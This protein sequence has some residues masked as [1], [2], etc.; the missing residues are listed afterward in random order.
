MKFLI[1]TDNINQGKKIIDYSNKI[2]LDQRIS[3]ETEKSRAAIKFIDENLYGLKKL[4][5]RIKKNLKEFREKNKSI[6]LDLETKVIIDNI[7]SLDEALN[8]IDVEL[9]N[10]S[11]IYTPNNPVYINLVNKKKVLTNQ[12][13]NILSEIKVYA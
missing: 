6:N 4:L 7:Q 13:D 1:Y 12:K 5:I 9:A 3:L 10:A 8:E 11:K 2:F